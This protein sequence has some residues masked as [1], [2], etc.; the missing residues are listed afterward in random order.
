LAKKVNYS[1]SGFEKRFKRVFDMSPYQWIQA[2]RAQAIYHEIH[3]SSKTFAELGY[4]F[5][6]S[7]PS[8][9]SNFCK[10]MFKE[11]PGRLRKKNNR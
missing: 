2:Q 10:Q 7:S 8:H 4:D 3:C 5:G 9:F 6:F 11:T 1:I